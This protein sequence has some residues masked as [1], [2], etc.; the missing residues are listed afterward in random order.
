MLIDHLLSKE[1]PQAISRKVMSHTARILRKGLNSEVFLEV[2]ETA[3]DKIKK[4]NM[5]QGMEDAD[6][7]LRNDLFASCLEEGDFIRA[8]E[9]LAG[10]NVESSA[11]TYQVV[12]KADHYVK[13]AE[14]YLMNDDSMEAE[15]F[16]NKAMPLMSEVLMKEIEGNTTRGQ[17]LNLRYKVTH[18]RVLDSNRKFLDAAWNYYELSQFVNIK[19]D[20]LLELFGKATTCAILGKAGPQRDRILGSLYKDERLG[21]LEQ[22]EGYSTHA[23]VLTKMYMQQILRR[24]ELRA[25][26]D[27]L[28]PH[29]KAMTSDKM[30]IPQRAVIEH[31]MAAAA[32]IYENIRFAE[33]GNVLEIDAQNAERIAAK[34]ISESRLNGYIDQI[35]GVLH[36][37]D[38]M[39]TLKNWDDRISDLCLQVN[40][41]WEDIEKTYPQLSPEIR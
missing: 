20:E 34:M 25:F 21:T 40:K 1:V 13:I 14:C 23:Q 39:D 35:D 8:A 28:S 4:S 18:S 7:I 12:E 30:T 9:A 29:Q 32:H 5:G 22:L 16:V 33:L 10:L 31:N 11:R 15:I 26:E 38:D 3:V 17:Q 6:S 36:L 24:T 19:A 27:S 37:E 2:A 41:S